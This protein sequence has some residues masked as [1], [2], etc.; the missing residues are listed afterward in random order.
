MNFNLVSYAIFF[1][2]MVAITVVVA[3]VCHKHGR[4]W[5]LRI[6]D[7]ET[8][9]V[10]AVN[11]VLLVGCYIVNFGYV[12]LVLSAWETI[13]SAQEMISTL[14]QHVALILYGLAGLHYTNITTLFIWAHSKKSKH[15]DHERRS[16]HNAAIMSAADTK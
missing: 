14:G 10:D 16:L 8:E 4:V 7:N 12:A 1:P 9:F 15:A 3:Q 5:M 2:A 13:N 11:N 6:F